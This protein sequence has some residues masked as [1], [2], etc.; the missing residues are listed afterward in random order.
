MGPQV[1]LTENSTMDPEQVGQLTL[2]LPPAATETCVFSALQNASF[3]SVCQL[4]DDYFQSIF[5]KKF[6]QVLDKYKTSL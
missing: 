6:L 4:C 2:T 5:N 1:R 3:V